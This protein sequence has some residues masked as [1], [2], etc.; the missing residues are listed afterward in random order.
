MQSSLQSRKRERRKYDSD[1]V[2][3]LR[4]NDR[5]SVSDS[6][7]PARGIYGQPVCMAFKAEKK[8]PGGN[9]GIIRK[10]KGGDFAKG[11]IGSTVRPGDDRTREPFLYDL[12]YIPG[13]VLSGRI[14]G[15]SA[16]QFLSGSS[17][18]SGVSVPAVLV[19]EVNGQP[20]QEG[21]I[22]GTGNRPFRHHDRLSS[23]RGYRDSRRRKHRV[24]KPSGVK[25]VSEFPDAD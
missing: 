18:G 20:L 21:C 1:S 7:D 2:I 15:N 5:G 13:A 12:R 6:G 8:Y 11:D 3:S 22:G 14:S 9:Q 23:D 19:C 17:H 10:K 24:F 16:W 4:G 25:G